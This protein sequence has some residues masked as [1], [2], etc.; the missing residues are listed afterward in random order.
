MDYLPRPGRF[1]AASNGG[2]AGGKVLFLGSGPD[3]GPVTGVHH[4]GG[5]REDH[6]ASPER[7]RERFQ[8]GDPPPIPRDRIW[9][10]DDPS[11]N[12]TCLGIAGV[13]RGRVYFCDVEKGPDP[14]AWDGRL[15]SA[16]CFTRLADSFAAFMAGLHPR[17][18]GFNP[19]A[20]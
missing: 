12:P 6:G 7:R 9:I 13:H 14:G 3:D 10:M 18:D 20:N 17:D 11:G 1:P 4:A 8:T 5:F 15:E 2:Y 19:S 16:G